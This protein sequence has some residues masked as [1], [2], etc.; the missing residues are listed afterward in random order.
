MRAPPPFAPPLCRHHAFSEPCA[1]PHPPPLQYPVSEKGNA[2]SPT[3]RGSEPATPS[4][5]GKVVGDVEDVDEMMHYDEAQRSG[6]YIAVNL[7]ATVEMLGWCF[8]RLF[9]I[10]CLRTVG[11]LIA[12]AYT[13]IFLWKLAIRKLLHDCPHANPPILRK[14]GYDMAVFSAVNIDGEVWLAHYKPEDTVWAKLV[15]KGQDRGVLDVDQC[16]FFSMMSASVYESNPLHDFLHNRWGLQKENM[17]RILTTGSCSATVSTREEGG[18]LIVIITFKGTSPLSLNEWVSDLDIDRVEAQLLGQ[19]YGVDISGELHGGFAKALCTEPSETCLPP[20]TLL[21]KA[22]WDLLQKWELWDPKDM[23]V[24]VTG[25]SLGAA[26]ATVFTAFLVASVEKDVN[27]EEGGGQPQAMLCALGRGLAGVCTFG[28]PQVA[29]R[30]TAHV[31]NMALAKHNIPFYRIRNGNDMVGAIPPGSGLFTEMIGYMWPETGKKKCACKTL[32]DYGTIGTEFRLGHFGT[33]TKPAE[34]PQQN[35]S[36]GMVA[37]V[38]HRVKPL[39]VDVIETVVHSVLSWV[40]FGISVCSVLLSLREVACWGLM[41]FPC[42]VLYLLPRLL[43]YRWLEV[44]PSILSALHWCAGCQHDSVEHQGR[45]SLDN[46]AFRPDGV[47]LASQLLPSAVYDHFPSGYVKRLHLIKKLSPTHTASPWP[48]PK[49]MSEY[50]VTN[51]PLL[52]VFRPVF[53][54]LDA[55]LAFIH[56]AGVSFLLSVSLL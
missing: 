21:L 56:S 23:R 51:L 12:A 42:G 44:V 50:I 19:A 32:P 55:I 9:I 17:V 7:L 53:H 37:T 4:A 34:I 24:W 31:V 36:E 18:K 16:I 6:G 20:L 25:H 40:A 33:Y 26:L 27:L 54:V 41:T 28:N 22:C 39:L 49:A 52:A 47:A 1:A 5:C 14:G 45:D 3:T 35:V 29:S 11:T 15:K 2:V 46:L 38:L 10:A 30:K 43:P 13:V 48:F 8:I